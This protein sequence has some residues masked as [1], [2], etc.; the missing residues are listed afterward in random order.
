[1]QK[2]FEVL[3][4]IVGVLV[5]VSAFMTLPVYFLWNWL[6]PTLFGLRALTLWQ[7][8]GVTLLSACLFKSSNSSTKS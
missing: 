5:V 3:A 7:A 4:A 6:M 8:L 2:A 1:M